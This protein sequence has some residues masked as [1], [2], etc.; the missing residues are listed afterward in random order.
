MALFLY[1]LG[2]ITQYDLQ[3]INMKK[4]LTAAVLVLPLTLTGCVIS[5]GGEG[6]YSYQSDWE[7]KER[8]NRKYI[9]QLET[10]TS[11]QTIKNKLGAADF[12]ELYQ[13]EEKEIKVLFYRTQRVEGDGA[14]TKDECTPLIFKNGQLVGWGETAYEMI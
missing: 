13:K 2:E 12:S 1:S 11:I 14:T 7:H 4:L 5:V 6:D 9:A 8:K 3:G 10:D